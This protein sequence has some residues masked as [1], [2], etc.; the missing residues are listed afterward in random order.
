MKQLNVFNLQITGL[1]LIGSG[2]YLRVEKD[3][4]LELCDKYSFVTG[5]NILIAVGVIVVIVA[6]FGCFGALK[7]NSCMLGIVSITL[8][9]FINPGEPKESLN[10]TLSNA[11]R[12]YW[13]ISQNKVFIYLS[14]FCVNVLFAEAPF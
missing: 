7:E 10:F 14:L 8:S 13:S 4:Y 11:R 3:D 5:A 6:F 2:A 1:G 12:F 9:F